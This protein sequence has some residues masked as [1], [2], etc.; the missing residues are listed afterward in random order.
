MTDRTIGP[1][2]EGLTFI[3]HLGSGGYSDVYLYEQRKPR[4]RVAV[5]VL[6]GSRLSDAELSQFAAEAE[7]MA[8][9]ADH[10][11]IVQVF[12][13]GMTDD[14]RPF[15]VMKFYPPPN[16][17][18]RAASER[19]SVAEVLRTGIQICSAVETAHRAGILHRDIKP[20]NI[21]LSQYNE[22]GLADFGIAGRAVDA[23]ADVDDNL[24]VSIHWSPPEVI[25]GSSNGSVASDVYSLGATLWHLLAG[26]SPFETPGGD[27]APRAL[28]GRILK[29]APPAT[30]RADSPASLERLLQQAMSK[31]PAHRPSSALDF[32]RSLQAVEQELRY[33]KTEIT[34]DLTTPAVPLPRLDEPGSRSSSTETPVNNQ[35]FAPPATP[36]VSP[37]G[38]PQ[39]TMR[40]AR[41]DRP[42]QPPA[43]FARSAAAP[44]PPSV[45]PEQ[46][47][48]TLRPAKPAPAAQLPGFAP[49]AA[50]PGD[51]SEDGTRRRPV[52]P[53]PLDRGSPP[54]VPRTRAGL[55]GGVEDPPTT[56]RPLTPTTTDV[57][58]ESATAKRGVKTRWAI[59]ATAVVI[60]GA[61]AVGIAVMSG[62]GSSEAPAQK[63][64]GPVGTDQGGIGS[65]EVEPPTF[66]PVKYDAASGTVTY[67]WTA[68]AVSGKPAKFSYQFQ[69]GQLVG[70]TTNTSASMKTS[71]PASVCITVGTV[72]DATGTLH[73][74]TKC[75]T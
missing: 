4:M 46:Q 65:P 2:I 30:G 22:P 32:S 37:S 74:A 17:G 58:A 70:P 23:E 72:D 49:R 10:P 27:N 69:G 12:R 35:G 31:N 48:T 18:Q 73:S 71:D 43:A 62:G 44:E 52:S 66:G 1:Q 40:P 45:A 41:P 19:F 6:T 60:G 3:E 28:V 55:A 11:F 8:E 14:G 67:T 15:L 13:T 75:G 59:I 56:H 54:G 25:S 50:P 9:L 20:A 51:E 64:S 63:P 34:V 61:A 53:Q 16:L 42:A 57:A 38:E 47:R 29:Q 24:G 26:R 39:T 68:P 21:L 5:K 33:T 7:T 36:S